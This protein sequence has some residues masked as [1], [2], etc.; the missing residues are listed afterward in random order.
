MQ[1]DLGLNADETDLF[2]IGGLRAIK[3][4]ILIGCTIFRKFWRY[5]QNKG[6]PYLQEIML[7]GV[8]VPTLRAIWYN[9]LTSIS[10]VLSVDT[11]TVTVDADRLCTVTFKLRCTDGTLTDSIPFPFVTR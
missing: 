11:L 4:Q 3:Q 5:D 2:L 7:K 6:L 9:F 8:T 10:G 1:G